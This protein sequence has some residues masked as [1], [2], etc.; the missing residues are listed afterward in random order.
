MG[1]CFW[2]SCW[3][4]KSYIQ[5]SFSACPFK[6]WQHQNHTT[7]NVKLTPGAPGDKGKVLGSGIVWRM[8]S[9]CIFRSAWCCMCSLS[10][11]SFL[12]VFL[13]IIWP[14][15]A[16]GCFSP[17][18]SLTYFCWQSPCAESKLK[19]LLLRIYSFLFLFCPNTW[20]IFLST[21]FLLLCLWKLTDWK[22]MGLSYRT[23]NIL[24]N[25][26]IPNR[27]VCTGPCFSNLFV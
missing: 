17:R 9:H 4:K 20:R 6:N 10:P 5:R 16:E 12:S 25:S 26:S 14:V 27:L 7:V 21:E 24:R 13:W 8:R 15:L 3:L 18:D 11:P 22:N 23:G 19:C 1:S 2:W